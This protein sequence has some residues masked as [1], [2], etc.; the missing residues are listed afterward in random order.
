MKKIIALGAALTALTLSAGLVRT[1]AASSPPI[2]YNGNNWTQPSVAR[3]SYVS[4]NGLATYKITW[5]TWLSDDA[6]GHGWTEGSSGWKYAS[7]HLYRPESHGGQRYFSRATEKIPLGNGYT[8]VN[9]DTYDGTW[10]VSQECLPRPVED[11]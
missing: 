11:C 3:T 9:N 1:A 10:V 6:Y 8:V 2:V 7:I 4:T 5:A